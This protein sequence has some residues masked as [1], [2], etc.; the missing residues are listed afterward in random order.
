MAEHAEIAQNLLTAIAYGDA[1]GL[2]FEAQPPQDE[3]S[4]NGLR[5][6]E[7]NPFIGKYPAGTWSDDT[8]LSLAVAKSVIETGG[9]DLESQAQW[10]VDAFVHVI[11]GGNNPD[12]VPPVVTTDVQTG[13]GHST[14]SSVERLRD[15]VSPHKSSAPNGA[16]NGVLMKMAPL[17]LWQLGDHLEASEAE[18]Q[19]IELT[20]MTHGAPEAKVAT[21]VHRAYLGQLVAGVAAD[22]ALV[23][24]HDTALEIEEYYKVDR[25][26]S[27]A[28]GRLVFGDFLDMPDREKILAAA[29]KGGF[30]APET[31]VMAY[32]SFV[33]ENALPDSVFRAVELGGD[34][35]STG[36]IVAAMNVFA[37]NG[38]GSVI[39]DLPDYDKIFDVKRLEKV[40]RELADALSSL[41]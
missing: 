2:P 17:V 7:T 34:S 40:G 12:M 18:Q 1:A 23:R 25:A 3:G 13:W 39:A 5:D 8:H 36:S 14:T 37:G 21:L 24:A 27:R 28:L 6:T 31:L 10:H 26:V 11:G 30:Y 22:T 16:G 4:L 38:S 9:F 29:P 33:L 41:S 35:D 32:G 15:G 19:L 20:E